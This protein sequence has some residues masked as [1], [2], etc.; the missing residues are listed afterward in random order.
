MRYTQI[1]IENLLFVFRAI[2]QYITNSR[3]T[4]RHLDNSTSVHIEYS[5]GIWN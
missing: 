2:Q 5:P 1:T 4:F 3:Q